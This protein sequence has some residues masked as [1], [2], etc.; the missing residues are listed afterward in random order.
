MS[1]CLWHGT[2][3]YSF[4]KPDLRLTDGRFYWVTLQVRVILDQTHLSGIRSALDSIPSDIREI[5]KITMKM[6]KLQDRNRAKLAYRALALL[7]AARAPLTAGAMCH[8]LG[9]AHVLD[10]EKNPLKLNL[11]DIPNPESIVECS[12]GL[13]K[14][15]P[16]TETVTLA[17]YDILQEMRQRWDDLFALEHTARLARTCIAY[18]SLSEF[19]KGPCHEID[20][21]RRRLEEY[22]FLDYASRYWGHHARKALL[23]G[24]HETDVSNDIHR[25]LKQQMNLRLSLQVSKCH[26]E[27][28]QEPLNMPADQFLGVSELHI[29]S[30]H[31]LT[32]IVQDFL[33]EDPNTSSKEDCYGRT[34]LHEAVQ[35]G[36]EDIV[37]ILIEAGA[38]PSLMDDERRTPLSYAA[39]R[40]HASIIK[41]L[42][43]HQVH[44]HHDRTTL[45]EALYDAAEAGER[46]VVEELLQFGVDPNAR[47]NETSAMAVASRKG[48]KRVV[49]LLLDGEASP[50]YPDG[51]TSEN[52]PLHQAIR[53]GHVDTASLLLDFGA[54]IQTR[55]N[56]GRTALF[57]TLHAQDIRG[58]ALLFKNGIDMSCQDF[59][60][61]NVLHE[62]ARSGAVEHA[63]R[64]V[65][66]GIATHILNKEGL[67]PL[68]LAAQ[69]G[70]YELAKLL[71]R[72][73]AAVDQRDSDGQ[74]PLMYA[75]RAGNTQVC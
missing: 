35:A 7:T 60:G 41:I 67:A 62:A 43:D 21:F 56:S 59:M 12:M 27:G 53:H 22:P 17:H 32:T 74:T 57:E 14:I 5:V 26:L 1:L 6:M 37:R 46:W 33:K 39:E 31:G 73:G 8:V 75:V 58:A 11:E 54:N 9:L 71:I 36:W 29:A 3:A 16:T 10:D 49:R 61:E 44:S 55:D 42:Q 34:A 69:N 13:I 15:E 68:H 38:D 20:T 50:S 47:K 30:R 25:F 24:S 45:E 28:K 64:F 70:H 40:G 19:S 72:T 23:L 52:I 4:T 65:D 63:S 48:H 66:Q 2:A 51:L 18:L